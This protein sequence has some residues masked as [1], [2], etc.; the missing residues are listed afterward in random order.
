MW[1]SVFA[2]SLPRVHLLFW[3]VTSFVPFLIF[4][5]RGVKSHRVCIDRNK[6]FV[7]P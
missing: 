6:V 5:K 1:I 7:L 4:T 3:K 2:H